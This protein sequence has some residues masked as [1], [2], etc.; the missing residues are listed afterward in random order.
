L[1]VVEQQLGVAE[2]EMGAGIAAIQPQALLQQ[3]HR[4]LRLTTAQGQGAF[5]KPD[6]RVAWIE[7]LG[8]R[9]RR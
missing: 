5:S 9:Q 7:L 8:P 1:G 6:A 3:P 4:L 2:I